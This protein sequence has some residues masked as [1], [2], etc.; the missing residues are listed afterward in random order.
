M[1]TMVP[2][3]C[4]FNSM[5]KTVSAAKRGGGLAVEPLGLMLPGQLAGRLV[6][7]DPLVDLR[8]LLAPAPVQALLPPQPAPLEELHP[9][10]EGKPR[11]H[12]GRV[13][14]ERP[15]LLRRRLDQTFADDRG[16]GK[17]I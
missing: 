9:V 11:T 16:H 14:D 10:S 2:A 13:V 3:A 6:S 4:L 12:L 15:D 1:R 5:V 17:M 7:H 8:L